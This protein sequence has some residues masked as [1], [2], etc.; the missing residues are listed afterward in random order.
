MNSSLLANR[1]RGVRIKLRKSKDYPLDYFL[2]IKLAKF[3][4][5]IILIKDTLKLVLSHIACGNRKSSV[6]QS[7]NAIRWQ[8]SCIYIY[9]YACIFNFMAT[10]PA[11]GSSQAK[12]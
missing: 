5:M 8:C 9:T 12:D 3:F 2:I 4:K 6:I 7:V 11:Y 10:P 1:I